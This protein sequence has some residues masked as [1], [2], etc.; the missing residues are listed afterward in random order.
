MA[1]SVVICLDG[2]G[3]DAAAVD[4]NAVDDDGDAAD[5][6]VADVGVVAVVDVVTVVVDVVSVGGVGGSNSGDDMTGG[7]NG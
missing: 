3:T 6:T 2:G 1:G 4:V 7:G 5:R